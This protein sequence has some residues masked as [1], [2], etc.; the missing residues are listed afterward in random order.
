MPEI[1]SS[2]G[3][4]WI[5]NTTRGLLVVN[6]EIDDGRADELLTANNIEYVRAFG[7]RL[8]DPVFRVNH[9]RHVG[10][11]AIAKFITSEAEI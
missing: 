3:E 7:E 8:R 2:R 11:A 9:K 5:S 1:A 10:L 6:P 4:V